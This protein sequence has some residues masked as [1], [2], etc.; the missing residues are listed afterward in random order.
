MFQ[1][2]RVRGNPKVELEMLQALRVSLIV[3]HLIRSQIHRS[4]IDFSV[5]QTKD[6]TAQNT[7]EAS[8]GN[9]GDD[10]GEKKGMVDKIKDKLGLS[11]Q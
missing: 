6:N 4:D 1:T 7:G 9:G 11:G 8:S 3:S 2:F 5:E 10:S